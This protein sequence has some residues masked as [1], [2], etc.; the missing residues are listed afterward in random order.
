MLQIK[1]WYENLKRKEEE[2][3]ALGKK[4]TNQQLLMDGDL[5]QVHQLMPECGTTQWSNSHW[6][7]RAIYNFDFHLKNV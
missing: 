1:Y 4:K 3:S 5:P 6:M 7:A 2:N